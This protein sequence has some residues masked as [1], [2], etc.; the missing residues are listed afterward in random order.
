MTARFSTHTNIWKQKMMGQF[1]ILIEVWRAEDMGVSEKK[2]T[3]LWE[4]VGAGPTHTAPL[5]PA[6][7]S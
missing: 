7:S 5:S 3:W 4:G 2:N 6:K 1:V